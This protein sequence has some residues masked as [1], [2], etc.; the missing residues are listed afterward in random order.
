MFTGSA[1]SAAEDE[2]VVEVTGGDGSTTTR[3]Y[4]VPQNCTLRNG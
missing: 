4:L 2:K 3:T 1:V